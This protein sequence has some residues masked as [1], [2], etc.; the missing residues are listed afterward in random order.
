[1]SEHWFWQIQLEIAHTMLLEYTKIF[2]IH[3]SISSLVLN[4][5]LLRDC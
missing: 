3:S 5:S 1:M 2:L 4:I